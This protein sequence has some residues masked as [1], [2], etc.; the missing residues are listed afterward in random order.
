MDWDDGE[1][2]KDEKKKKEKQERAK[3]NEEGRFTS[4]TGGRT[5]KFV[6]AQL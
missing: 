6:R 1:R 5:L 3:K 2:S 4:V